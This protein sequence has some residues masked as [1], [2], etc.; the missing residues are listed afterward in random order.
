MEFKFKEKEY[1]L[2]EE[3]LKKIK[4][5]QYTVKIN[6]DHLYSI[7]GFSNMC[8]K[9][10]KLSWPLLLK[11]FEIKSHQRR[12]HYLYLARN[13]RSKASSAQLLAGQFKV[14]FFFWFFGPN[15]NFYAWNDAQA[16]KKGF[17]NDK[18]SSNDF[19]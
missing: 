8:Q 18:K 10:L 7:A 17:F 13:G 4:L 1:D 5:F 11:D 19:I 15:V 9:I 16:S 2:F 6:A 14:N 12:A 3:K